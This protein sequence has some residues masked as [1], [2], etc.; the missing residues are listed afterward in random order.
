MFFTVLLEAQNTRVRPVRECLML[1]Q[2]KSEV[3]L[4]TKREGSKPN[5]LLYLNIFVQNS[6]KTVPT[7]CQF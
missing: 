7:D 5:I 2:R 4:K 1:D 6:P 3:K